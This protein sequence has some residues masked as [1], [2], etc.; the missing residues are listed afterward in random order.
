ME[1]SSQ[2]L[3]KARKDLSIQKNDKL[4]LPLQDALT[5]RGK[6][7]YYENAQAH[8]LIRLTRDVLS[9]YPQLREKQSSFSYIMKVPRTREEVKRQLKEIEKN[10]SKFPIFLFFE[11]IDRIS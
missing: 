7:I 1:L 6:I 3:P 4:L 9:Q 5:I 11:R 2:T 8:S 10:P